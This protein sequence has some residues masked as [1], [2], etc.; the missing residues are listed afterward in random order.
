MNLELLRELATVDPEFLVEQQLHGEPCISL[1]PMNG[2]ALPLEFA[3]GKPYEFFAGDIKRREAMFLVALL[4]R[5]QA[6][7]WK[8]FLI[9]KPEGHFATIYPYREAGTLTPAHQYKALG[10]AIESSSCEALAHA[11]VQ[12]CKE[13]A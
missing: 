4:D 8:L 1:M 9:V 6:R 11:Y 3:E 10:E 2:F 13:T 12:A 7:G 5:I